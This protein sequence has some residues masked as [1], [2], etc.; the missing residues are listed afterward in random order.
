MCLG[1]PGKIIQIGQESVGRAIV[2]EVEL[3]VNL[4]FTPEAVLGDFVMIHAGTALEVMDSAAVTSTLSVLREADQ[5]VA[6]S[7][8]L[9]QEIE[10]L[11]DG[12]GPLNIMEVCGTHTTAI[13]RS[14]LKQGL[15]DNIELI[16]GPGCPVCVTPTGEI[17]MAVELALSGKAKIVTFGD[18]LRVPGSRSTLEAAR[19]AGADVAV[20][21]SPDEALRAAR[22]G[23]GE[24]C[25]LAVGF[26]TTAPLISESIMRAAAEEL[27]NFSV[28]VNHRLIP[29]ALEAVLSDP[30]AQIDALLC[31]GHVSMIIGVAAYEPLARKYNIPCVVAGFEPLDVLESITMTL[32]QLHQGEAHADNQYVRAVT[33]AGNVS[34]QAEIAG[35]FDV[36][37]GA[38]RGLGVIPGS[39]LALRPEYERFDAARRFNLDYKEVP[40]PPGCRCGEILGARSKPAD[41]PLLGTSCKPE[42]PVGPC[43][44]SSEGSCRSAYI[45]G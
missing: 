29:P 18:M 23:E 17:D 12:L 31:P 38:W 41:C 6:N 13:A 30:A 39:A 14:G 15:P 11:A 45:Y 27:G 35:V 43:M 28:L 19:T 24:V 8:Q 37:D 33:Q 5:R 16:S 36:V 10:Q 2:G 22:A 34:A 4:H 44:V 40:E 9:F 20:A 26:E 3:P 25:F 7:K 32:R 42:S 21:Y 1:M